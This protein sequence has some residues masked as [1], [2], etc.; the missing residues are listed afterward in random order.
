MNIFETA[1]TT[2]NK[3]INVIPTQEQIDLAQ[4]RRREGVRLYGHR[5]NTRNL[6]QDQWVGDLGEIVIQ[7]MLEWYGI[8]H[9]WYD[10]EEQLTEPDFLINDKLYVDVKTSGRNV[11]PKTDY[12]AVVNDEQLQRNDHTQQFFFC[13][14]CKPGNIMTVCGWIPKQAYIEAAVLKKAGEYDEMHLVQ[15]DRWQMPYRRLGKID[16]WIGLADYAK[17]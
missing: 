6:T 8:E 11:R 7:E 2:F 3:L 5:A 10:I 14:Y 16:G 12:N 17:T 1:E 9:H 15:Y 4:E 13:S